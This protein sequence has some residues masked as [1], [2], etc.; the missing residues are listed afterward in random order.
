MNVCIFTVFYRY[1][2]IYD[3]HMDGSKIYNH[4]EVD[5]TWIVSKVSPF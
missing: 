5:R 2:Y 1:I 4:S 3:T